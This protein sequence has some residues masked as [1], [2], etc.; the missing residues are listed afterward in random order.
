MGSVLCACQLY[1]E[2]TANRIMLKDS[3]GTWISTLILVEKILALRWTPKVDFP[4]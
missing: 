3:C 2:L 4:Q 1:W